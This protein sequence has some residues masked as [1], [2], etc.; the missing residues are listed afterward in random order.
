MRTREEYVKKTTCGIALLV[1]LGVVTV[2][3][4]VALAQDK[5]IHRVV[6]AI[7]KN[8]KS[9]T[10]FDSKVPLKIGGAGEGVANLWATEKA[11]ADFSWDADRSAAKKSFAP[12]GRRHL[13]AHR[14]FS[15]GWA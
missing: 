6:T 10:L 1:G 2:S 5:E 8:N 11:P 12:S 7:D 4:V 3:S 15:S 14:R 13:S 9:V